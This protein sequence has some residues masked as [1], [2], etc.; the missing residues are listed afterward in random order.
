[1]LRFGK[2]VSDIIRRAG[3]HARVP[4]IDSVVYSTSASIALD[5]ERQE[6]LVAENQRLEVDAF[7]RYRIATAAVLPIGVQRQRRDR[8]LA[9]AEFGLAAR[10]LSEASIVDIVGNAATR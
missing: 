5:N 2:P 1:V 3:L 10:T 8:S 9:H 4:F 6:V 7:V